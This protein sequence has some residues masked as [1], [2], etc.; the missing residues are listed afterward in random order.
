MTN[1]LV[2]IISSL[3]V[4]KIKKILLYEMKFLLP[5]YSCLQ[6][7]WLGAYVPRS[8]LSLSS[9]LNWICWTPP[10]KIPG[11][12]TDTPHNKHFQSFN[13]LFCR[14]YEWLQICVRTANKVR[15]RTF[16]A[17]AIASTGYR[18][19]VEL[20]SRLSTLLHNIPFHRQNCILCHNKPVRSACC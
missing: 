1:K 20:P 6:N 14:K 15:I 3:K 17:G 13:K 5:I 4:P 18:I 7:P 2:V 9:V 11:Y 19:Y 8:P 16:L 12:A 10:K